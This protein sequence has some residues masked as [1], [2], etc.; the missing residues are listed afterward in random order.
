[1]KRK[2]LLSLI[3]C[4]VCLLVSLTPATAQDRCGSMEVL[5]NNLNKNPSLKAKFE[6]QKLRVKQDIL[7]RKL[8]LQQARVEATT[9]YI[10]IVFHIVLQNPSIVTDAQIQAQVDRLN[11]DYSGENADSTKIPSFFKPLYAKTIIQFKLAQR[12]PNNESS[13]GIE[14]VTTTRANFD[15]NDARVKYA[16]S[17]GADAWDNSRF[18]NVWITNLSQNYLGYATFPGGGLPAEDGVVVTPN[19]LPGA[20][21]AY[22]MGRTLVHETGHFFNLL[23]IWGD[24]VGCTG[25]DE[26]DDTPNQG[27]YTS[28][29]PSISPRTDNCTTGGNGI[30][31]ENFMDYTD[32]AC[33]VMFTLDQKDRMETALNVY[34]A[35][36]ITSNG[37]DP[38]VAYNLDAAAKSINT[39]LQRLCSPAFAP[40]I[41]LRN[42]GAQTLTAVTILASIDNGAVSTTNWTGSLAS[43]K[44]TNVTLNQFTVQSEG[45]HTLNVVITNA[46]GTP[47]ENI[48]NDAITLSFLYNQPLSPPVTQSFEGVAFPPA[49][50]DLLNADQS[51][52]WERVTGVGKTGNAAAV[53][54]NFDYVANGRRDYLRLP[55]VN[56]ANVD[57]AFMTFQL[58]AAVVT[59]PKT[60]GNQF[61]TLEVLVS[62]DCGATYTS[63]YK[64]AGSD[65]IT[66]SEPLSTSFKPTADEWRKDS[67]N[68]T[69]Y[70]NA[71]QIL[72]A[73]SNTT[74]HE[75]NIYIDDVN[76]YTVAINPVLKT[77]GFMITPNPTTDRINVQFF[78]H[79]AYVKGINIFSSTGQRVASLIV[80][81]SGSTSYGF[82]MSKYA[83]GVYLV[84]VVLGDKVV[85]QK[86]IKR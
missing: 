16:A 51:I 9:V 15:L 58:A 33:M 76:V 84:Q 5:T 29:C 61:D 41:T 52:T 60:T 82:D 37:A 68:L 21:G 2:T 26:I 13:T 19:S 53:I 75:N 1:M 80:N 4:L 7:N 10:P 62:K 6:A 3:P 25:S 38:V 42:T 83:N 57:S 66:H 12:N 77:K 63:L 45:V 65:L 48:A 56:I 86:V 31:Y 43:L 30:M 44:E 39:P 72:L 14:R 32:D 11:L 71:G 20:I 64:K 24:D 59:D 55:V 18:F 73:F 17:G 8:K 74:E 46:N 78:P 36:L 47:D 28:G 79:A 34:R 35:S 70:I 81:S 67:V 22:G 50:W 40:V 49:G 85:T 23:H 27:N 69:P 54:R